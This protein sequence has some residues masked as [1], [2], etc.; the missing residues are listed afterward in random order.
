MEVK[1]DDFQGRNIQI[2]NSNELNK[3]QSLD[4]TNNN[5]NS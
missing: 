2:A 4:D 3:V 5:V 1:I